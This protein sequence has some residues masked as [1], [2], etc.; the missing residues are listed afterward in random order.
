MPG[1]HRI[2]GADHLC[3]LLGTPDGERKDATMG[4]HTARVPHL[5]HLDSVPLCLTLA[6]ETHVEVDQNGSNDNDA[7]EGHAG[8][9][10]ILL[11]AG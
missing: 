5:L 7:E 8:N 2:D 1:H 10:A 6:F 11:R 4:H 9:E 3:Q